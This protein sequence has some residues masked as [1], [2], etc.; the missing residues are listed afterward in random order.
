MTYAIAFAAALLAMSGL[1]FVWLSH[2][3]GPVYRHYLG[4]VM[5]ENPNLPAAAAFY[6]V[7]VFGILF[8]AVKPA[9]AAGQWRPAIL[10]G[11]LFGFFA[12]A[13]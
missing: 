12:F 9:L 8:F 11:A 1:D 5:A 7:Y 10:N 13:T 2:M 3:A 6:I 4:A